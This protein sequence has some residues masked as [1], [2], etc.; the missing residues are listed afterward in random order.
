M[1]EAKPAVDAKLDAKKYPHNA[2]LS[3]EPGALVGLVSLGKRERERKRPIFCH[4]FLP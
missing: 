2:W 1:Y 4:F 3:A